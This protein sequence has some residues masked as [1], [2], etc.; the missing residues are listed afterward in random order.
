MSAPCLSCRKWSLDTKKPLDCYVKAV[1]QRI[2]AIGING[3]PVS[4]VHA[5]C[6]VCAELW[7]M[8]IDF[9]ADGNFRD[10]SAMYAAANFQQRNWVRTQTQTPK[11]GGWV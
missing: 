7:D 2:H 8:N 4:V 9:E 1:S 11:W 5:L 6:A 10:A 3:S